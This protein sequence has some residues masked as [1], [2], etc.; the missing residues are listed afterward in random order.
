L[1][2]SD[3]IKK[4]YEQNNRLITNPNKL[5]RLFIIVCSLPEKDTT[6]EMKTI[7]NELEKA[8]EELLEK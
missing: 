3:Y 8:F 5:V 2:V 6:E 7:R 4:Y 1:P